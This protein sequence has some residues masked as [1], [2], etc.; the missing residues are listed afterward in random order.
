[1]IEQIEKY[2]NS[3]KLP[4][5]VILFLVGII[6]HSNL[7][8]HHTVMQLVNQDEKNFFTAVADI[9]Y[10]L[11]D[12]GFFY[13]FIF[14]LLILIAV[15]YFVILPF[16]NEKLRSNYTLPGNPVQGFETV[17]NQILSFILNAWLYW[18]LASSFS[19]DRRLFPFGDS[20]TVF[21]LVSFVA[22]VIWVLSVLKISFDA[23]MNGT[24]DNPVKKN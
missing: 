4:L 20:V 15:V 1:M 22:F 19:I 8:P 6:G 21:T 17:M 9:I 14:A 5:S 23:I 24:P 7:V 12:N 10:S 18:L 11:L 2:F 13:L 16:I 3:S